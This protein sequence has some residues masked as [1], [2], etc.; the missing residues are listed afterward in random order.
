VSDS[1]SARS[2]LPYT[3]RTA[4]E[5]LARYR[6]GERDFRRTELPEGSSFAG[7]VLAGSNFKDSWLFGTDFNAAD[8]RDICFD[9]SNVKCCDFRGADLRGANIRESVVCGSNFEGAYVDNVCTEG[10]TWYGANVT[11]VHVLAEARK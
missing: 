9:Q 10:T 6:S 1:F 11:D 7:S 8:L 2:R 3:T 4:E 5:I